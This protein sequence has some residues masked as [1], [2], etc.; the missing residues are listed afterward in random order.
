MTSIQDIRRQK[1]KADEAFEPNHNTPWGVIVAVDGSTSPP[2]RPNMTWVDMYNRS[3]GRLAVINETT[4]KTAGTPVQLGPAPKPPYLTVVG[5]YNESL[6][7]TDSTTKLGQFN[8]SPHGANHQYP[9]ES[10]V[11]A[12][13]VNVYQPAIQMLKTTG[14][15]TSLV[16]SVQPL[17]YLIDGTRKT[18]P[19]TTVDLTSYVPSTSG[20]TR[21]V[22]IYLDKDTNSAAVAAGTAVSGAVP[23][24]Y[25]VAPS[26]AIPSCYAKLTYGQ[27]AVTTATHI[28]DARGFLTGNGSSSPYKATAEGQ[29]IIAQDGEFTVAKPLVDAYGDI[30]TDSNG[31]IVT[32]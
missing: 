23:I 6:N 26:N 9:T 12:D 24:P 7:P 21:R 4:I 20:Q 14:D 27:T 8:T 3:N 22:L 11:G 16:C 30:V 18:Y 1:A 29:I 10:A 25:P 17:I 32:I 13:V 19:G 28:E 5:T 15:G 2:N 31:E